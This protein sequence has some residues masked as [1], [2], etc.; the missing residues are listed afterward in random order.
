[1]A[2]VDNFFTIE[3]P[4]HNTLGAHISVRTEVKR[5]I[6]GKKLGKYP[7]LIEYNNFT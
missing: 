2:K 1:M 7:E 6:F 5:T 3:V 4:Q